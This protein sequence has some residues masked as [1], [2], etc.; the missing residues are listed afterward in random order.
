MFP[1]LEQLAL[2]DNILANNIGRFLNQSFTILNGPLL[3]LYIG[4]IIKKEDSHK[5]L[6]WPHSVIFLVFYIMLILNPV[7]LTPGGPTGTPVERFHIIKYFGHIN[8]GV[9][10]IYGGLSLQKIY[11]NNKN[12]KNTFAYMHGKIT[13]LWLGLLPILF[14]L[15]FTFSVVVEKTELSSIIDT[16][17]IHSLSF[18][19]FMLYLIYFGIRQKNIYIPIHKVLVEKKS[20]G[21]ENDD[22][23]IDK[24]RRIML[25]E[26]L[27]RNPTLSLYDLADAMNVSRHNLTNLLNEKLE[28]NFFQ[29][30]NLYRLEEVSSRIKDDYEKKYN[31]IEL[32]YDSGFNSKS[33]FNSLFKKQYEMTPTQYRS[34]FIKNNT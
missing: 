21:I 7:P 11:K 22:L 3:Y 14:I 26:K 23:L 15:F 2:R 20:K 33:S 4:E 9:F 5:S 24:I 16:K 29:F 1:F 27:Y 8:I 32:A 34:T 6:Y 17:I 25:K 30:V 12:I 10:V 19:F 28:M 13:L 31:I 18:F